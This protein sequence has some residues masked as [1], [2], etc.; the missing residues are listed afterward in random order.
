[1]AKRDGRSQK[2]DAS[3]KRGSAGY[4]ITCED[5]QVLIERNKKKHP[6]ESYVIEG[7]HPLSIQNYLN[8]MRRSNLTRAQLIF[9]NPSSK[10]WSCMDI[11]QNDEK[12][13]EIFFVDP[14]GLKGNLNELIKALEGRDVTLT[15]CVGR[16]KKG[17]SSGSLFSV[18][19]ATS[20]SKIADLH[21]SLQQVREQTHSG[22]YTVAPSNL[23]PA[24]AEDALS[25][26]K[27]Q[28]MGVPSKG[29]QERL[30][31]FAHSKS[32]KKTKHSE[33][34]SASRNIKPK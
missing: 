34:D 7:K 27:S 4:P 13:F 23:P 33:E 9:K 22:I 21:G 26:L 14:M 16:L 11:E 17:F 30:S 24:L 28:P 3:I 1:M 5:V 2:H 8:I 12:H 18:E 6:I 25:K 20:M 19:L 32:T 10:Y 31:L 15:T 29:F